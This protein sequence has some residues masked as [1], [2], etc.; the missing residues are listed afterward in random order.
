ADQRSPF[1]P[2]HPAVQVNGKTIHVDYII[3]LPFSLSDLPQQLQQQAIGAVRQALASEAAA[4][5]ATVQPGEHYAASIDAK[6]ITTAAVASEPLL[7]TPWLTLD[8][9]R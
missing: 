9:N 6:G 8:M 2:E 4:D 3:A 1:Y 7:A 5:Q